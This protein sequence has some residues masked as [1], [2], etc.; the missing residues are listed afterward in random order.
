MG[1]WRAVC[2]HKVK[3]PQL[4]EVLWRFSPSSS[5]TRKNS[6]TV[7]NCR[8]V[9][10]NLKNPQCPYVIKRALTNRSKCRYRTVATASRSHGQPAGKTAAV[11][12]HNTEPV[13][14]EMLRRGAP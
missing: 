7:S 12:V 1:K 11:S 5:L 14:P 6:C 8:L 3:P 2:T 13:A 9:Q 4:T 10:K